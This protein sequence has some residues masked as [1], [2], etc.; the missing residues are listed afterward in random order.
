MLPEGPKIATKKNFTNGS[1]NVQSTATTENENKQE[2]DAKNSIT[3]SEPAEETKEAAAAAAADVQIQ[4]EEDSGT[5]VP[6][7]NISATASNDAIKAA[8]GSSETEVANVVEKTNAKSVEVNDD[9]GVA[10]PAASIVNNS[11]AVAED[12]VATITEENSEAPL[13]T[14]ETI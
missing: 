7:N 10:K 6:S 2:E 1:N 3:N 8:E 13:Q 14:A 9:G 11:P 5:G 4:E 12:A